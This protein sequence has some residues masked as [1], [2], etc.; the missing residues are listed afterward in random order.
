M[1]TSLPS[2]A[3]SRHL[4]LSEIRPS[5]QAKADLKNLD[6]EFRLLVGK[7]IQR[8]ASLAGWTLKELAAK[9][10]RDPSQV[11]KWIAGIERPHFDALFAVEELRQPLAQALAE[12]AGCEVE[13]VIRTRRRA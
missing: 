11:S 3:S 6:A 2:S 10:E 5:G 7:A 9:V 8:A 13:T 4:L 1:S 12:M